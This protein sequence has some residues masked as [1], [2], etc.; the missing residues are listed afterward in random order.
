MI[1]V[2]FGDTAATRTTPTRTPTRTRP[3]RPTFDGPLHNEIPEPDRDQGQLHRLAGRTTT[4]PLPGPVL[5]HRQRASSRSRRTTRSSPRAATRSTAR[6]P[7]GSRSPYNEARY[8]RSNGYPCAGNVCSNAWDL[9]RDGV[10]AWVA[11]QKAAGRTDAADQG[12][13]GDVRPVGPLRLRRRRQLQRARRLHRPLP[14]RARRRR[15]GRRR[16]AAGR[17]RHLVA[18]LVRLRHHAG[19][20]R[21]GRQPARRHPDRRHRHLGRRLHHPAG[22]R[23]PVASSPTSTATTSVCRTT[24][25]PPAAATTPSAWWTLMAQSRARH[26][27]RRRHRRPARRHGRLGQAAARLAGLR[28]RATPAQN[29]TLQARAA[30]VQH[31]EGAGRW[32]SCCRRRRSPPTLVAPFA[33][34]QAVVERQ[35]RRPQQ[36]AD[37]AGRP[38]GRCRPRCRSRLVRHRGRTTTTPTSRSTTA[39]AGP[40]SPAR[41]TEPAEGNGIDGAHRPAGRTG[42]VRPVRLR[43]QD[44]SACGS[45]TSPTAACRER[46]DAADGHLRRRHHGDRR[47]RRRCSPTVPRPAPN[48]WTLDGFSSVGATCTTA[49]RQLLHRREPDLHVVRQVPED[50]SVQLRLRQ[51]PAGLGRALPVPERPADL[52]LGHLAVGQQHQRAPGSGSDPADRRASATPLVPAR[53]QR[54]G[55]TGSRSTTRPFGLQKADSF[56]LHIQRPAR[57]TSAARTRSRCSTTRSPT[58]TRRRRHP[59][60]RSRTP[61]SP[62]ECWN[63]RARR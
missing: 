32:S 14:D 53:R 18:P 3:G 24:T 17:G 31:R 44:R 13:P 37:P 54:C 34:R 38:A 1:L 57:A 40:P 26:Q 60:S 22:E 20:D 56:T 62:Y 46:S 59:A 41:I 8:G 15:P 61:V 5:R 21:P 7:T 6:S 55:A 48:G 29:R 50:R 11:D 9:V 42:D 47:R 36:H 12:R 33:G 2:E 51:H 58:R 23:R 43:R 16:P 10:N 30:R 25:T 35:R 39:P 4:R 45:A 27:E 49:V 52:L 63:S 28:D 19:A